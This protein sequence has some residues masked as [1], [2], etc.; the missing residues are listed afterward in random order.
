V[1]V[2]NVSGVAALVPRA[3][4]SSFVK[5]MEAPVRVVS[6]TIL[7]GPDW[8]A[9]ECRAVVLD[10][11]PGRTL[12]SGSYTGALSVTS[13]V[14]IAR[15]LVTIS[16]PESVPTPAAAKGA[17]A[18]APLTAERGGPW[19][20]A[21]L[22]DPGE[23]ALRP[24]TAG[25]ALSVPRRCKPKAATTATMGPAV[26][27]GTKTQSTTTTLAPTTTA[28]PAATPTGATPVSCPFVGNLFNGTHV[29][30]V[31]VDGPLE[32]ESQQPATLKLR[33]QDADRVGTY[34]GAL[35]LAQTPTDPADDVKVSVSVKDGVWFAIGALILGALLSL[36]P[37]YILRRVW[38][39]R[40]LRT[41]YRAFGA[42]Y[43]IAIAAFNDNRPK[44]SLPDDWEGPTAED[45][46]TINSAI[47][48]G[49]KS[50]ERST[51]YI[52]AA[53]AA[54]KE[55]ERSLVQVED[56]VDY[57]E[58]PQ[59]LAAKLNAL[60]HALKR[61]TDFL[62]TRFRTPDAPRLVVPAAALLKGPEPRS[63]TED[64]LQA[65][66]PPTLLVGQALATKDAA[67][68]AIE[69]IATWRRLAEDLLSYEAWWVRLANKATAEDTT[70]PPSDVEKLKDAVSRLA[71]AKYEL[72][73]VVHARDLTELDTAGDLKRAYADLAYLS[74][75]HGGWPTLHPEALYVTDTHL[76]LFALPA[77]VTRMLGGL[78]EDA[79]H[80]LETWLDRAPAVG[81]HGATVAQLS[82]TGGIVLAGLA[83]VMTVG[84]AILTGLSGFYFGK[85]WGTVEDYLT[86]IGVAAGAQVVVQTV[87]GAIGRL[88]PT[89]PEQLIKGPAAA[90]LKP[91]VP[92]VTPVP[93]V[94]AVDA[95]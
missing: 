62:N 16:G 4:A 76:A 20:E 81:G 90:I 82:A 24:A 89:T 8:K 56:D 53:S 71:E 87:T 2:C 37:Q 40:Q 51:V 47:E 70:W 1:Q 18:T 88:L 94:A 79:E 80:T 57:L 72:L 22:D 46:E 21:E 55:L 50:Y 59:G 25:Q 30:K 83:L 63:T 27:T 19:G 49:I 29:A 28:V 6:A 44:T 54:Y 92:A 75:Q 42:R 48:D 15:R 64:T 26:T 7:D 77:T 33:L 91:P 13:S 86:V 85:N 31:F 43:A 68:A 67:Q 14:G 66:G 12:V 61:L 73:T 95:P 36:I 58:D 84:A 69:L 10:R 32:E 60:E 9:G 78:P 45:I 74:G 65:P 93:A 23:L 5:G 17:L 34:T 3:V 11:I 38:P 35:D 39:K 52:D 41:R